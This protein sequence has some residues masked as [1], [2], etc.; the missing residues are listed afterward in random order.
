METH[1]AGSIGCPKEVVITSLSP[2]RPGSAS[3]QV[4]PGQ[5][6]APLTLF[7]IYESHQKAC[8]CK[9]EVS[10]T[11]NPAALK[12]D[13]THVLK[14]VL[15]ALPSICMASQGKAQRLGGL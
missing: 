5:A 6:E 2:A 8:K 7:C 15:A 11:F 9:A 3:Q 14:T 13:D 1:Q 10:C 12:M 4:L